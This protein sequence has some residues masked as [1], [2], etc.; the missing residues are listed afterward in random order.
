MSFPITRGLGN[1]GDGSNSSLISTRGYGNPG[2]TTGPAGFYVASATQI[3]PGSVRV[4]YSAIPKASS[5]LAV[6]D[7]LNLG[8]YTLA[9]PAG[10]SIVSIQPVSGDPFSVD[11]VLTVGLVIGTWVVQVY[12]VKTTSNGLLIPPTATQFQVIS[13]ATLTPLSA[14]AENDN[15]EKIIRKHLSPA[16][17]GGNWDAVIKALSVGDD[18]NWNNARAAFDQLF[19]SSASGTYLERKAGDQGLTKPQNVGIDD[20]SFRKLAIKTSANKVVHEAIREIL[21]VYYGQ[22]SLRAFVETGLDEKYNLS[23]N[24]TL[25]WILDEKEEFTHTFIGSQLS[26]PT[27][28]KALEVAIALTKT[29]RE[30]GSKGFASVYKSPLSGGYKVR[31][32]S[33][34]LG[35]GSFVRITGGTAQNIFKFPTELP[36]YSGITTG[37]GCNWIYTQPSQDVTRVSLTITGSP[38]LVDLS[39]VQEGDYV[40]IGEDAQIGTTG[41]F[42]VRSVSVNWTS[43]TQVVQSFDID[44]ITF[45]GTANQA[46]NDAYRFYRPTK[47][48]IAAS[49][50]RTVVVAQTRPGQIDINI[51]A[52]TQIVSRG[53]GQAFYGRLNS[54]LGIARLLRDG[55]GLLTITTDASHGLNVGDWVRLDDIVPSRTLAYI[56]SGNAAVYPAAFTYAASYASIFARSQTP[57]VPVNEDAAAVTLSNGQILFCG[58]FTRGVGNVINSAGFLTSTSTPATTTDCNRYEAGATTLITDATEADGALRSGHSWIATS[59]LNGA[60]ERHAASRYLTG[61][62]VSGGMTESP[63]TILASAEEYSLGGAW[64]VLASM[65]SPRAGHC[66]VE[67][68]SGDIIAV[69][70]ATTEGIALKTTEV[71]SG[72]GAWSAGATMNVPRTDFQVVKLSN[73]D[74]MAIGGRTMGQGCQM[75]AKTLALWRL[76]ESAG[77]TAA[78]DTSNFPLTHT[79][80]PVPSIQ[81]KVDG[82]LDFNTIT[83]HLTGA[84]SAGAAAA[85][86]GEWTLEAWFK[87]SANTNPPQVFASYGAAGGGSAN[88]LLLNAGIDSTGRIY[89][90]WQYGGSIYVSGTQTDPITSNAVYRPTFFNHVAVRKSFSSPQRIVS[91]SRLTNVTT[92]NFASPHGFLFGDTVFVEFVG[93]APLFAGGSKTLTAVTATSISYAEVA[94]DDVYRVLDGNVGKNFDVTLF[95]NGTQIQTWTNQINASDGISGAWYIAKDPNIATGFEGFLDDIRVSTIARSEGEIRET[96]LR[97]WGNHKPLSAGDMAIGACTDTC[98]IYNGSSWTQVA[99]MSK[100]RAFHRAVVLPGDYILVH[101]GLGYDATQTPASAVPATLGLWPSNSLRDAEIYDPTVNRWLP[102]AASGIRRHGHIMAYLPTTNKIVVAGGVSLNQDILDVDNAGCAEILDLA[103]KTWQTA[104]AKYRLAAGPVAGA[105]TPSER[106]VVVY[107]GFNSTGATNPYALTYI[108][109]SNSLSNGGLN[110]EHRVLAV[111]SSTTIQIQTGELGYTSNFGSA[112]IGDDAAQIWT[113]GYWNNVIGSR[114]A[115]VTTLIVGFPAGYSTHGFVVGDLVYANLKTPLF[116]S[117][118]KTITEVT[119]TSISYIEVLA[120]QATLGF[121]G[122]IS[123]NYSPDAILV[124]QGASTQALNDPGPYIFAPDDGLA[125]TSTESAVLGFPLYANQNYEEVE[126][127]D[128]LGEGSLFPDAPGYIVVGFGTNSQ[129]PPIKYLGRYKD[130]PTTVRLTLDYSYKFTSDQ[131]L[132]TK[133]TLLSQRSPYAPLE[134]PGSAYVTASSAGRVAAQAAAEAALAAGVEPHVTIAFPGDRGLGGEGLPSHGAQKLSDKVSVFGGDNLTEEIQ[135]DREA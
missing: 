14:G 111:P 47:N 77:P 128:T 95:V 108:D 18:I 115:G 49:A 99:R 103:S 32:Y 119:S 6:D 28:G 132:G 100:A 89:W 54:S 118:L 66:Q 102:V 113:G 62:I 41:T 85:L 101:G 20:E 91:G 123:R 63:D 30:A 120:D 60:R 106:E 73:G 24:P 81:G 22:D 39:I 37:A 94:T 10:Y 114:T 79:N 104:P 17:K 130:S 21:E 51:P 107:G 31:I 44:R 69:G 109:A 16:L 48:S 70:G 9:G 97:G 105:A 57:A 13:N 122:S 8:N 36:T 75:D 74:L 35:L 50:G 33:G 26:A 15:P 90:Q 98:E 76:D 135:D 4:T 56:D 38:F 11:I 83:S 121:T 65:G 3:T 124:D 88:N 127:D 125:V 116:A 27:A 52:T 133:V 55:T 86:L 68:N 78:D 110:G 53:P 43:G 87:L 42:A 45:S 59:S 92:L 131:V 19:L 84:G 96:F 134:A 112:Y 1:Q 40:V 117:G 12:N 64:T 93:Y 5:S 25:S 2:P 80:V 23:G 126:I 61:A 72:G 34:S 58:G 46:S 71:F 82:C 7:A 67:L 129:T 29:M